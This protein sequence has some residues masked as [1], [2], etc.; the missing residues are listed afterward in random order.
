MF[1]LEQAISE[2]R[3][4]MRARGIK[5]SDIL[6]E[7]ENHLRDALN[8]QLH[9]GS[10]L[11]T[12]FE[13]ARTRLGQTDA[14]EFEFKKVRY[15]EV[16]LQFKNRLRTLL[17]IPNYNVIS[18]MN[19]SAPICNI[20]PRWATYIKAGTFLA[21]SLVLWTISCVFLMPKLKQICGDAGFA[22]PIILQATLFASSHGALISIGLIL[23]FVLLEWRSARWP[24]YRRAVIGSGVYLINAFVLLVITMMV[25]S[26][27]VAAPALAQAT[28]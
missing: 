15:T 21:P 10:D 17:G 20:E 28:L 23:S 25:F 14:L 18:T 26:A 3:G 11:K 4:K 9:S 12:A 13:V 6:D 2:W 27:L 7:L 22:L 1:E 19:T 8:E 24:S 5:S 16:L